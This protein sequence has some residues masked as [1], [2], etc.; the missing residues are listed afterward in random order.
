[1]P[2]DFLQLLAA[3]APRAVF[4]NAPLR[5]ANLDVDD[6]RQSVAAYRGKRLESLYPDAEHD[7]PPD[8]RKR[9]Y[10]FLASYFKMRVESDPNFL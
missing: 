3:L 7:F 10:R 8:A 6:L 1:M 4:V 5:D 9:A 2:F